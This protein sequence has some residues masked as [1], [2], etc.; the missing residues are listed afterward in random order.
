[1]DQSVPPGRVRGICIPPCSKSYAQRALAASLLAEGTSR[2]HNIEFCD[3]TRS[4]IRCIEALGARVRRTG[5]RTLEIDGGLSPAGDKLYVGQSG[6]STRLFTPIASLCDTPIGV[7]GEG[8]LLHRSFRTMIRTLRALGVRVHDRND[9]LPLHIQGPIRGGEVQVE[10]LVSSQ[11]ITGLL[12]ALPIAEE[13]TTIHVPH[14]IS[15]PY[16]DIT[17]DTAERFG[18]EIL[19]KDYKE[20]YVAGG[21]RYRPAEFEIESDWSAAAF[22][23][24]AGA[25][26]GEVTI[27]N[28]SV[29]SRQADTAVMTAL[30]RA[31]A[32]V[33]DEGDTITVAHRPLQAFSFDAT[34]CPGLFPALAALAASAE[35]TSVIKGTSRLENKEGNRAESIR[36]EYAKLGIEV[37]LD[38]ED[39]MKIRGGRIRGG[40]V[41]SHDDHRIAM[42]L[43][44]A[45]LNAD[46]P[47]VIENPACVAKTSPT[48]SNGSNPC[49]LRNKRTTMPTRREIIARIET[50]LTALYG[51]REARQIARIVVMELGGLCLTDLV[52]EPNKELGIDELDRIIGELTAGR[53]LQYVLGHTEFYG[54]DFQV[55]E[56]VLI[57][58]PETE[59]L[60]RWIA[61]SPAPDNPAVLDVGTGS[62]CIAVTLARLIPGARVTAVDISE[63]ALSI[64]RENARRLDAKVD[65]RQGDALGELFPGQREQFDLIVSNPPYIPRSEKASMRVNVT[66]YEPA[67]ALFVE[68]G[69]PLIFYRAI[70]RNARR[71]LRPGGRLYF[72]IHEN[73]ADETLRMLTR[74]GFPDTAVRRDLNDKNRMTCSLQRR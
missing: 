23:L 61:E 37:D 64:A 71:L 56:G 13:E 50:P 35:G 43:A 6:L 28:L 42:S 26:A 11:F 74:E 49:V 20:F 10:G 46:T 34:Q 53:P 58:R 44:V 60:V 72:E 25:V 16:I 39:T 19:H 29:L 67:E 30:I 63:K 68:D 8:P 27:H 32:S 40:H 47:V 31:G 65:F 15:T 70:A 2:L 12:L 4:A 69:D 21:Q 41:H 57:P 9:H 17:I 55:R 1:M 3:D 48:S 54:L 22:L 62:G 7:V 52:A 59:E 14:V 51:E 33:I 5:E 73:F 36:E 18:I 38:E 24:V 45:A 66:G